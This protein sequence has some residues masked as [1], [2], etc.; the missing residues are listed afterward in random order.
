MLGAASVFKLATSSERNP[1]EHTRTLLICGDL[2]P[3]ILRRTKAQVAKRPAEKTEQTLYCELGRRPSASYTTNCG[4]T[5]AKPYS[6]ALRRDGINKAQDTDTR[7][8]PA[9]APG[10]LPSRPD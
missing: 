8:P 5:T 10:G 4:V 2:R 1:D 9:P 6:R 7:S 3:F